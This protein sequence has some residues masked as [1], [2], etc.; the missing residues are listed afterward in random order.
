MQD[1]RVKTVEKIILKRVYEIG[2]LLS[3]NN[4]IMTSF[5]KISFCP[6]LTNIVQ[7][8]V[9]GYNIKSTRSIGRLV[10]TYYLQVSLFFSVFFCCNFTNL[11]A[12]QSRKHINKNQK[13]VRLLL[14]LI[15]TYI[16]YRLID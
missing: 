16:T 6:Y 8:L 10:H 13:Q 4:I 14:V 7:N 9:D 2:L 11:N 1:F 15:D 12:T 5:Q 3:N